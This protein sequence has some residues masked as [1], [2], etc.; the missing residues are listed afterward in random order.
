MFHEVPGWKVSVLSERVGQ[1]GKVVAVDLDG[2]R[3]KIAR[4][5]YSA[6]NIEYIEADD[7]TF[8]PNIF[9]LQ[10]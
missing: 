2:E 10:H 6:S 7:K 1:E 4:E 8:P 3:L 5:R 9:T